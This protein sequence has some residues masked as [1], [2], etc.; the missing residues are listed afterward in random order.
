MEVL[1]QFGFD[2]KL[3][4][5]QILN[6]LILAF[7]FKR[8]LYKPLLNIIKKREEKIKRGLE[9]AEKANKVL[10]STEEKRDEILNKAEKQAEDII[11]ESKKMAQ[12][13]ADE[14]IKKTKLEAEKI[15]NQAKDQGLLEKDAIE[16]ELTQVVAEASQRIL[17]K[18]VSELFTKKEKGEIMRRSIKKIKNV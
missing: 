18:V 9:D 8:Y 1:S 6:F 17:E 3:F 10:V 11:Q 5:A 12:M 15:I 4:I 7:L 2:L 14:I 16:K 13:E